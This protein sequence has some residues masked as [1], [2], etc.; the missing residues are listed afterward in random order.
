[1]LFLYYFI[2]IIFI[3]SYPGLWEVPLEIY[4][5]PDGKALCSLFDEPGCWK[6]VTTAEESYQYFKMNFDRHYENGTSPFPIGGH[7][8]NLMN[9]HNEQ[10]LEGEHQTS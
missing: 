3:G 1:M 5:G 7:L 4:Y 10:R 6:Q 2:I 9:K 8:R